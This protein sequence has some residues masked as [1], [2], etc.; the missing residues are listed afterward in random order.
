MTNPSRLPG[1]RVGEVRELGPGEAHL[2]EAETAVVGKVKVRRA[3]GR[4][5]KCTMVVLEQ[6]AQLIQ[7]GVHPVDACGMAG[8]ST[9]ARER[10]RRKG[11]LAMQE[12]PHSRSIYAEFERVLEGK[13]AIARGVLGAQLH[14]LGRQGNIAAIQTWMKYF[15][16]G[17]FQPPHQVQTEDGEERVVTI[18][19]DGGEVFGRPGLADPDDDGDTPP[20]A[21]VENPEPP[22]FGEE[23]E[24]T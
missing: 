10:W 3:G 5:T 2:L 11:R 24:D 4:P 20:E 15:G 21:P 17:A 14:K 16:V 12:N 19:F 1:V 22:A 18:E 23:E 7:G 9:K 8:I 13:G 6:I